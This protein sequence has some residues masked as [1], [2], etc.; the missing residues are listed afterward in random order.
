MTALQCD[1]CARPAEYLDWSDECPTCAQGNP[2]E[3]AAIALYTT[4]V[5]GTPLDWGGLTEQ[6]RGDYR[7]QARDMLTAAVD[8][9]EL[10]EHIGPDA[11]KIVKIHYL[12]GGDR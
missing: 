3:R 2:M 5:Y 12:G 4:A 10:A 7:T 8:E 1:A 11:A 6:E 9:R